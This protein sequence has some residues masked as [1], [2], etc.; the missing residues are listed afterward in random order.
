MRREQTQ[1]GEDGVLTEYLIEKNANLKN[2]KTQVFRI[3]E[4]YPKMAI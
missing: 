4:W 1:I 3:V 2:S